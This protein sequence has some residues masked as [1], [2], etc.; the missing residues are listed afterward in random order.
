MAQAL[1]NPVGEARARPGRRAKTRFY[2][3]EA[4]RVKNTECAR[5]QGCDAGKKVSGV[6][7]HIVVDPQGLSHAIVVTP[8]NVTD[9]QGALMAIDPH[10]A[11][12]SVVAALRVDGG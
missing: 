11:N 2:L 6:K 4:Q 9:R 7:R 10:A 12:L 8:A 5:S 1:K 3:V